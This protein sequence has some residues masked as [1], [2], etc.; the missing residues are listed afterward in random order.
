MRDFA[1]ENQIRAKEL[2]E[3]QERDLNSHLRN[4]SN[5]IPTKTQQKAKNHDSKKWF[6]MIISFIIK[7]ILWVLLLSVVGSL[8]AS[9][10]WSKFHS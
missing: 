6:G 4:D 2:M 5:P 9:Y 7:N 8:I 3:D 1:I 10:L